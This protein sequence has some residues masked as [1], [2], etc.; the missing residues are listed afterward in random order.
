MDLQKI[1][2]QTP[3]APKPVAPY[4]QGVAFGNTLYCSGQIGLDPETGRLVSDSV[5]EQTRQVL[6]NLSAILTEAGCSRKDVIKVTVLLTNM[7]DFAAV[8]EVYAD[9][10]TAPYPAR[11]AFAVS[12]LPL[13]ALVEIEA[14]AHFH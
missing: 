8:N 1:I 3:K 13:G 10:F 4:S 2:V 7:N 11:T 6:Q 14:I 12:G 9:F 5:A